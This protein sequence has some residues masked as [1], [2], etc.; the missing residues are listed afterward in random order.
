MK[1]YQDRRKISLIWAVILLAA[2]GIIL[3]GISKI[4]NGSGAIIMEWGAHTFRINS[5]NP[6]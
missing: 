1:K 4:F 5:Q 6:A 3:Y 2:T